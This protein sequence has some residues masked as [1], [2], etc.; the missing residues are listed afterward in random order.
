MDAQIRADAVAGAVVEVEAVAPQRR[1]GEAV[2]LGAR[3]A[4]REH[5]ERDRDHALEHQREALAHLAR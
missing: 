4:F 5:G 3:G 2:D 1:A